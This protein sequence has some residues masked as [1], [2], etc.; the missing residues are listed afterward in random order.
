MRAALAL[1]VVGLALAACSSEPRI[2]T[3]PQPAPTV[4]A[5]QAAAPTVVAPQGANVACP[6]GAP[7]V[8]SHGVYQC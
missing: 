3:V 7:A 4:V 6:N 5:P 2:V 8:Y 1:F